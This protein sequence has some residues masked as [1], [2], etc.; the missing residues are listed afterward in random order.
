[1]YSLVR[2]SVPTR[3]YLNRSLEP[4]GLFRQLASWGDTQASEWFS[5]ALDAKET[6]ESY[7]F[8]IDL[9]GVEEKDVDISVKEQTLT[10]SGKREREETDEG[11]DY[12]AC[13][14]S[15]G[16]FSRSFTLP[17]SADLESVSAELKNGVLSVSVGKKPESQPKQI[18]VNAS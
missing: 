16:S 6:S 5:P 7:L 15:Y 17:H 14:R 13:E 12:C 11:E 10:I 18:T 2:R 9:P 3:S 8:N 1:M 4:Y